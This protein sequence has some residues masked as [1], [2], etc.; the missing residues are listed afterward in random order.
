MQ[1]V[2][3]L[4]VSHNWNH[5]ESNSLF[6]FLAS[7]ATSLAF[8]IIFDERT[9]MCHKDD[10]CKSSNDKLTILFDSVGKQY[11]KWNTPTSKL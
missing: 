1:R 4:C 2:A 8:R 10:L 5:G 3:F 9:Q 11:D 7:I 6:T